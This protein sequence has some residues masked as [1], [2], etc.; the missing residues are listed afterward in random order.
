[1]LAVGLGRRVQKLAAQPRGGLRSRASEVPCGIGRA[2]ECLVQFRAFGGFLPG[3][4]HGSGWPLRQQLSRAR[5]R[6]TASLE[7]APTVMITRI[8]AAAA[9][10]HPVEPV[11][12]EP[13]VQASAAACGKLAA[14]R[15]RSAI[16]AGG[17]TGLS[18]SHNRAVKKHV[19]RRDGPAARTAAG[20]F[21][22]QPLEIA[23]RNGACVAGNGQR[24]VDPLVPDPLK[25][26]TVHCVIPRR[27]SS[28]ASWARARWS[29]V[30]TVP[31]GR[32]TTCA[33]SS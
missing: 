16:P 10:S 33:I 12:R 23:C 5:D 8:E 25:F 9:K 2:G 3:R 7:I 15:I 4:T 28:S 14:A 22:E 11:R 26:L 27:L 29:H 1:M 6:S 32:V 17:S 13:G 18:Q 19:A 30:F 31:T 20:M 21:F 24:L